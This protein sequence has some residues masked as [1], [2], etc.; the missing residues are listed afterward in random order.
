[1][2]S[3]FSGKVIAITGAS[4]GIGAE[5]ARQLSGPG[6][7]LALAARNMDRLA[8]VKAEC[9]A[10]G[11]K[12]LPVRCDV[13]VEQDCIALVEQSVSAFGGMD[14]LVNNAGVSGHARFEEVQDFSWYE[15]M[16]R[17]NFFG[18]L[19]CTRYALPHLRQRRGLVV[20]VCSLAGKHG[21]PGRT[22]YSPTKFAQAGFFEAL[23][24]ELLGSG[25]D[26]T[27]VYPGVVATGIR[28][29]GYGP[30]G[31]PA[32]RSGLKEERAMPVEE[33]AGRIARAMVQRRRE[34]IMTAQGRVGQWIKLI[35]PGLVDRMA[36]RA[37]KK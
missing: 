30:D 16:M 35:A 5:L 2:R 10:R 25:V 26:V 34:L 28:V 11:A 36:L 23:R 14:V 37:L 32:G 27:V 22:A 15:Q 33:C 9:E 18:S 4:D 31:K 17:V 20:G 7:S 3:A 13:S 29:H 1:L 6:V 21:I 24:I 8:A 12:A 19:W